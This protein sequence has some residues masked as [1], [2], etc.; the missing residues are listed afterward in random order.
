MSFQKWLLMGFVVAAVTPRVT[1]DNVEKDLG[2]RLNAK[3]KGTR[4]IVM[5]PGFYAG[6]FRGG[7]PR[8]DFVNW[9]HYDQ[10]L[11][12]KREKTVVDQIDDRTF[13]EHPLFV[14]GLGSNI[15]PIGKGEAIFASGT[16]FSCYREL[17]VLTLFLDT[18]KLSKAAGL[19]PLKEARESNPLNGLGCEFAFAFARETIE[20]AGA[21]D[22]IV[23]TVSKYLQPTGQ[24]EISLNAE[25]TIEIDVGAT[26]EEVIAKLGEPLKT[27]RFGSQKTLK[28]PDMTVILKDGKVANVKVE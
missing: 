28:Y 27:V 10:G 6:E 17:C 7:G 14:N 16:R 23:A 1:A 8:V 20:K 5:V 11:P 4:V 15:S 18:K 24:A 2:N 3:Y 19:D 12:I 9:R 22:L 21:D 26:E 25:K 13:A